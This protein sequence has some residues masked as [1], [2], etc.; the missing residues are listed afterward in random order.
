[1]AFLR[2]P[3]VV[4]TFSATVLCFGAVSCAVVAPSNPPSSEGTWSQWPRITSAIPKDAAMEA[5][6]ARAVASMTLAQKIGQMTQPEIKHVTPEEVRTYYIG[7]VLNG[8]GSWPRGNKKAP[9]ADWVTLSDQYYRASMSTDMAVKVPIIWGTDAIH[10][11][12][13]VFGATLFPHNIG[14]GAA[15]NPELMREIGKAV[16]TQVRAT[17]INW[18]FGPTLAVARDD[19]WGRTYESFSE[20]GTLVRGY[21]G[22]YVAGMQGDLSEP[23]HVVTSA[24]H[25]FGDGGT[26]QGKDQGITN[27]SM[28]TMRDVHAQGYFTALAAGAQTV[29]ASF[30]SWVETE[31]KTNYGKMHGSR[32]LLTDLLRTQMGFDGFV[33][34]D[35]NGIGQIPGCTNSRCAQAINAGIDMVMVPEEWRTFITNTIAQV[36]AGEIPMSRIDDAV[37]RI[38]RVKMRAGLF[39]NNPA[40]STL[41]G[42]NAAI[43]AR[44]LARRAVR[45][46]LVLLKNNGN[47]L[48][49][50]R[51]ARV[52]VVGKSAHSL[53]NQTGGWTLGWQ[54]TDN[55]NEDFPLGETILDG[56]RRTVGAAN[57]VFSEKADGVDINQFEAVIAVIGETP[58][59]EGRGDIPPSGTLA[60]STRHPEDLAV[61]TKVGAFGKPVVTVLVSGRPVFA[62]DLI[63]RSNAFVAAWLPGTEGG[64]VADVLFRAETGSPA[65]EFSGRLSFSWPNAPCQTPLNAGDSG[66]SP[67]F[68]L[69]YGLRLSDR[70][71]VPALPVPEQIGGCA[72]QS[73]VV[74]FRQSAQAPYSLHVGSLSNQW[75]NASISDDVNALQRIPANAPAVEISTVQVNTQQDAKRIQ[76]RGPAKFFAWAPQRA[77]LS[78]YP[79]GALAFDMVANEAP[80]GALSIGMECGKDCAAAFDVSSVV[81]PA[82]GRKFSVKIPLACFAAAGLNLSAVEVPFRFASTA[83]F[84][85]AFANIR[86]IAD[87][88]KHSDAFPCTA[89]RP[90][91]L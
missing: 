7:S 9:L 39:K 11:H 71:T 24:K 40:R 21:A 87:G 34:S 38:L 16:A 48:P 66:Y 67:L 45:E 35:W 72:A 4:R 75:P 77:A 46:S 89:L 80:R 63:N 60:H 70:T 10:G 52:L 33:V 81:T 1:M 78:S 14:L 76:W 88:A 68:P 5:E 37:T 74:I 12:G 8:G 58:Y 2:S 44:D 59:A 18:I 43:A 49:L 53:E 13:N 6:I 65:P 25:F 83:P 57:V 19:R 28:T 41:A 82:V 55:K 22:P 29:M 31:S 15:H 32:A 79:D 47:A 56:I 62:N 27:V 36:N 73:E 50:P 17:G 84:D 69:H 61:L 64:G 85:A 91:S 42:K 90:L 3:K 51:N 26:D 86:I 30:N 20:D 23:H 54:G